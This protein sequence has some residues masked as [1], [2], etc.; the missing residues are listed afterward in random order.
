MKNGYFISIGKKAV[1]LEASNARKNPATVKAMIKAICNYRGFCE[2][3]T[4][5]ILSDPECYKRISHDMQPATLE[6]KEC[7]HGKYY[8]INGGYFGGTY[9]LDEII[10]A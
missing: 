2:D 5:R 1:F 9:D 3:M 10:T 8:S 4:N 7:S 6:L